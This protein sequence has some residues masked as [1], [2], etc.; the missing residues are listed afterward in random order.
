MLKELK[1]D[2]VDISMKAAARIVN[3][4]IDE[5]KSKSLAEEVVRKMS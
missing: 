4:E 2:I 3:D 1:R 5:K